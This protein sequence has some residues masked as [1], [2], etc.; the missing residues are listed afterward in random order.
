MKK[1]GEK[2]EENPSPIELRNSIWSVLYGG[3]GG[4]GGCCRYTMSAEFKLN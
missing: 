4:E 2:G 1:E 3:G